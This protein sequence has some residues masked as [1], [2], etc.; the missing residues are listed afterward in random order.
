MTLAVA[1][2]CLFVLAL[3]LAAAMYR[4]LRGPSIA[5]R[6]AA[7]DLLTTCIMGIVAVVGIVLQTRTL[8]DV[9]LA[10]AVLGFFG[11][12]AFAKYLVGG[13]AID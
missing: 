11:T 6:V 9:V 10:M 12:V 3:S 13:R 4:V 7:T 1:P 5:D 2:Y 8:I